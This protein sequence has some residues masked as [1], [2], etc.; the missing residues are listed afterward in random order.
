M[1]ASEWVLMSSFSV[2]VFWI[3]FSRRFSGSL[4]RTT[5]WKIVLLDDWIY[6]RV[7]FKLRHQFP[8]LSPVYARPYPFPLKRWKE[9]CGAW[10]FSLRERA[11]SSRPTKLYAERFLES[12]VS[13][14]GKAPDN[15]SAD[16]GSLERAGSSGPRESQKYTEV[17][18]CGLMRTDICFPYLS[19]NIL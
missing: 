16:G 12:W 4:S 10:D 14:N 19:G 11:Q 7:R 15:I 18:C 5:I 9:A 2:C 8:Y 6:R 13:P 3:S 17:L 1:T